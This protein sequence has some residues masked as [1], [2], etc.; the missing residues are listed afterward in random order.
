VRVYL[1]RRKNVQPKDLVTL[2]DAIVRI[3]AVEGEFPWHHLDE[4]ELFMCWEGALRIEFQ[5]REPVE[6]EAAGSSS[7]P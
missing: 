6:L 1:N 3:A 4:D 7:F 5:D 2:N